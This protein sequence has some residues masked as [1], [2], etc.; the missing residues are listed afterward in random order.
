MII[1]FIVSQNLLI[2]KP[3]FSVNLNSCNHFVRNI[4]FP[5]LKICL[6]I[7]S[8]RL[9][10]MLIYLQ[11]YITNKKMHVYIWYSVVLIKW[12]LHID[13]QFY[14]LLTLIIVK[15]GKFMIKQLKTQTAKTRKSFTY[16]CIREKVQQKK[17]DMHSVRQTCG[18]TECLAWKLV[19]FY[20]QIY[21]M[22]QYWD[23]DKSPQ[24]KKLCKSLQKKNEETSLAD[25][26]FKN[27]EWHS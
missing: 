22:R 4:C 24:K 9:L 3:Y 19:Y 20:P 13:C 25:F 21:D 10:K 14:L 17:K 27:S 7:H 15:F 2:Y 26:G 1:N 8:N 18:R 12:N 16:V 5:T 6:C 11:C 23:Q